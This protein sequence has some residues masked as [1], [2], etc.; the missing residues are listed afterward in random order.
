MTIGGKKEEVFLHIAEMFHITD[1]FVTCTYS[2]DYWEGFFIYLFIY[3][4]VLMDLLAKHLSW[5]GRQL[6]HTWVKGITVQKMYVVFIV[7]GFQSKEMTFWTFSY[8]INNR[9]K[10]Q[11]A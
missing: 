8:C 11:F 1:D 10:N 2:A 7:D 9:G 5:P 3:L 4:L 6:T